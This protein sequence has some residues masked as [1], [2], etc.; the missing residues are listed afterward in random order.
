MKLDKVLSVI[1]L[2]D[3]VREAM[4]FGLCLLV[5]FGINVYAVWHY[6]TEWS[7]LYTDVG[8]MVVLAIVIYVARCIFKCVA[9]VVWR[10]VCKFRQRKQDAYN[11]LK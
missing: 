7:E 6:Q 10:V 3:V 4:V 9:I 11:K 1:T 5:A 8:Y 2:R